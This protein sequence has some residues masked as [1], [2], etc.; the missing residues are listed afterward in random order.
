M[1]SSNDD[2]D[3]QLFELRALRNRARKRRANNELK[4]AHQ[5]Y[6]QAI[7]V[8]KELKSK[9]D[10]E[11]LEKIVNKIDLDILLDR[12][13]KIQLNLTEMEWS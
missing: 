1:R 8:A 5:L 6:T 11:K 7:V 4:Q 9:E 13:E 2:I 12:L 10:V 3:S